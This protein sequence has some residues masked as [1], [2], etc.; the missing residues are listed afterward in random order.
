MGTFL[1]KAAMAPA[2]EVMVSPCT[3]TASGVLFDKRASKPATI[4]VKL[5]LRVC[6]GV[7]KVQVVLSGD[8][9]DV[10]DLI[11]HFAVLTGHREDVLGIRRGLK[12]LHAGA[13][14]TASGRVP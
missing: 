9:G 2:V 1:S 3:T 12:R 11:Q 5:P 14:L 8:A 13:V 4:R 7:K 10:V 6:R